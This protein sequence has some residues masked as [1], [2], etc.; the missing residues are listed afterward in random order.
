MHFQI[1][2]VTILGNSFSIIDIEGVHNVY[3]RD[4]VRTHQLQDRCRSIRNIGYCL[5]RPG[6]TDPDTLTAQC[7]AAAKGQPSVAAEPAVDQA[8]AAIVDDGA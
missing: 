8:E 1:Y 5:S 4:L 6:D 7:L 3:Y 2:L